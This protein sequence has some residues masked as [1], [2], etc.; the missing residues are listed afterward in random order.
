MQATEIVIDWLSTELVSEYCTDPP[1]KE[2]KTVFLLF[3]KKSNIYWENA[4]K[5]KLCIEYSS[6]DE[7]WNVV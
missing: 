6:S 5:P 4:E 3:V 1:G 7:I 2:N